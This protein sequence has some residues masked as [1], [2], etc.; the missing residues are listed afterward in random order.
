[1][2]SHE[3]QPLIALINATPAAI[4]PA[5]AAF[6]EHFPE[7]QLWNLLDD[8]LQ[9]DAEPAGVTSALA[10]RMRRLINHAV[11]EGAQGILLTC[12]LYGAVAQDFAPNASVP[13]LAPDE[14]AFARLIEQAPERVLVLANADG[15][16]QDTVARFSQQAATTN[17]T[18]DVHGVVAVGAA[19][20]AR[21][22]DLEA[23]TAS[24]VS[25]VHSSGVTP[26]AILLGQYSLS[27]ASKALEQQTGI[28]VHTGPAS[29]AASLRTSIL[30]GQP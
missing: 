21:R 5:T 8:R 16:L 28:L 2:Q 22:G 9:E 1:M 18:I 27:P 26:T 20:A 10:D 19:A 25:A 30:G 4:G 7:A 13:V 14:V 6:A 17:T 24:L 29:A 12:S 3:P 15:P 11:T 23:L